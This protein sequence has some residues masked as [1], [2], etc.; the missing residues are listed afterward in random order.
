MQHRPVRPEDLP[1]VIGFVQ[2]RDE[3]FYA[4]PKARW[5]FDVEQLAAAVAARR[6]S[7]LALLDDRPAAFANFYQCEPGAYCALGNMMVAP[8]ARGRGTARYLIGA[9]EE[10]ARRDY[11]ARV[12][13]ISCFNANAAG[14]LLYSGLGY[15][16]TG[17]V[18]RQAPDGQRVALVQMEKALEPS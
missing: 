10:Q 2:D 13:K 12:M 18:E 8:W 1:A 5:P 9:M 11:A 16:P 17:I 6:A 7:T 4:Y 3:L 14:L 15:R